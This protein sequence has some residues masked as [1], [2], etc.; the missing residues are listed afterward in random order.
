MQKS[1]R[2]IV[3]SM[4]MEYELSTRQVR[5]NVHALCDTQTKKSAIDEAKTIAQK[6]AQQ[7]Q[8]KAYGC[9]SSTV[10]KCP[11]SIFDDSY[12]FKIDLVQ[13]RGKV[14]AD[15]FFT[16]DGNRVDPLTATGG[17]VVDVAAFALRLASILM[18]GN[19][20]RKILVLDEPFKFVSEEYRDNICS[21]IETLSKDLGIQIIMVTHIEEL[22]IGK[23]IRMDSLDV[24]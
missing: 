14:E 3:D 23:I 1:H 18:M 11:Q 6:V 8:Q 17:G 13:K 16:R 19:R 9:I 7:I 5:E 22:R 2:Q 10:T 4:V 12:E 21:L 24:K 20:A 15:I